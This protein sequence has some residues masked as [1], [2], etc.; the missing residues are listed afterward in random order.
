M[1]RN[2]IIIVIFGSRVFV[3]REGKRSG[4]Y[5]L[6]DKEVNVVYGEDTRYPDFISFHAGHFSVQFPLVLNK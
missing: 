2:P 3:A 1:L 5:F 4:Q 6:T